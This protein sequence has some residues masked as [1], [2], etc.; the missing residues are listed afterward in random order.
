LER[1]WQNSL[2][3]K[4]SLFF[5]F[6]IC[7]YLRFSHLSW[8]F[9]HFFHPD[10]N[11]IA[12]LIKSLPNSHDA[13]YL[14]GTFAYGNFISNFIYVS[15]SGLHVLFSHVGI[16]INPLELTTIVLALRLVSAISS[17][18]L[19]LLVYNF[20]S[21]YWNKVLGMSTALLIGFHPG[22][23]QASH[24]GTYDMT[25]TFFILLSC[26]LI[27]NFIQ[28]NKTLYYY[29]SFVSLS[30]ATAIKLNALLAVPMLVLFFMLKQGKN[31][32]K[33]INLVSLI[34]GILLFIIITL[35]LSPY[36]LSSNFK[37]MFS[38][39]RQ[40]VQGT[41]DVFYTRQFIDTVPIAFQL[42]SILPYSL[43]FVLT[44]F[45]IFVLLI[46]LF[47][48]V[49]SVFKLEYRTFRLCDLVIFLFTITF[50]FLPSFF[51][52]KWS[53]YMLPAFP[54]I[55]ILVTTTIVR[56]FKNYSRPLLL[57]LVLQQVI[58]GVSFFQVYRK[59]DSRI[60]A[61]EWIHANIPNGSN[62][63]NETANVVNFPLPAKT[64]TNRIYKVSTFNFY[65]VDS[66]PTLHT[67][68][69]SELELADYILIP[70]RR[71]FLGMARYSDQYPFVSNYYQKL[72]D[73]KLGFQPIKT[74]SSFPTF[75]GCE[76]NDEAAEETWTVFDHPVVR[77][78]KKFQSFTYEDYKKLLSI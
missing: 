37:S 48:I 17:F 34:L 72:F 32:F 55:I 2:L 58:I 16:I 13:W 31:L 36:Y 69:A 49:L 59:I 27:L 10:E 39:E 25:F 71:I 14:Q 77:I 26:A 42:K 53:R 66:D 12:A 22:F 68:L 45:F 3:K 57:F 20:V 51:F 40:L 73:G 5:L 78:Y 75:F 7:G 64:G 67:T 76:L 38:Y 18:M 52:T 44:L 62:I 23:I 60:E 29:L 65:E 63:L 15:L 11:N 54:F 35:F 28:T 21:F 19:I 33:L 61:S 8:G 9:P 41:I 30:V 56:I 1:I 47:F 43:G 6:T 50:F 46:S 4:I 74:F 70:S 24:F